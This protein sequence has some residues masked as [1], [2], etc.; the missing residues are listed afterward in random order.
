MAA[1]RGGK[2]VKE[3]SWF[4]WPGTYNEESR[5]WNW[6]SEPVWSVYEEVK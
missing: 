3:R 2:V 6:F 4:N 1:K 5:V